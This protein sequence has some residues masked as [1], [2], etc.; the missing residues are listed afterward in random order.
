MSLFARKPISEMQPESEAQGGMKRVLGAGDLVMLAI[1][2]AVLL[3][4]SRRRRLLAAQRS[5]SVAPPPPPAPA[6]DPQRSER[7]S[8]GAARNP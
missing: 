8:V 3:P 7:D 6:A 1:G 5:R 4:I 2:A